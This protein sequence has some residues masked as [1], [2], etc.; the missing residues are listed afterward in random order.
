MKKLYVLRE[1]E[2]IFQKKH[3]RNKFTLL[4]FALIA[5]YIFLILFS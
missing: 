4:A 1:K 5:V 2:L 3:G